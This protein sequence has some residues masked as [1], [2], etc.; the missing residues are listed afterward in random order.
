VLISNGG[1][2]P[3]ERGQLRITGPDAGSFQILTLGQTTTPPVSST[4]NPGDA[5]VI[6]IAYCPRNAGRHRAELKVET[7][8]AGESTVILDAVVPAGL[9]YCHP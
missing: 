4:L 8:G 7:V 5:E 9:Q 3:V 1:V 2:A 6:S